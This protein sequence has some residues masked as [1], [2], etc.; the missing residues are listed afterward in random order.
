M[1]PDKLTQ[2]KKALRILIREQ[3]KD[4][5]KWFF[6]YEFIQSG[7][8]Y[9]GYKAPTRF[10]EL[11]KEYPEMIESHIQGKYRIGRLRIDN[12]AEFLRALPMDLSRFVEDELRAVGLNYSVRKRIAVPVGKN[13]VRFED[14]VVKIYGLRRIGE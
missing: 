6:P 12:S 4:L 8:L 9:I 1:T 10:V 2:K 14:K 7:E 5:T 11:C 13:T 3:A